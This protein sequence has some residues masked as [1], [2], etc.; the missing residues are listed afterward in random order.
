MAGLRERFVQICSHLF[1]QLS[2]KHWS[3]LMRFKKRAAPAL[4][5][6]A[7]LTLAAF[8]QNAMA[9]GAYSSSAV[10][11]TIYSKNHWYTVAPPVVGSPPSTATITTVYYSYGYRFPR[12]TG[13]QVLLCDNNGTNCTDVTSRGSGS[14]SFKGKGVK[15]NTPVRFHARVAGNGTMSPLM[16]D[17][18]A[19]VS[20]MYDD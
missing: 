10:M 5:A 17:G 2:I 4:L 7:S 9:A 14:V 6:V 18:T 3:R 19:N 16:G 1:H 13:F 20:V 11:P 15:A 12:P 8:A